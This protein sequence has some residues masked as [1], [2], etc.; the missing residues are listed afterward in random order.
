MPHVSGAGPESPN[1][2]LVLESESQPGSCLLRDS[3]DS[4]CFAPESRD[5]FQ[6]AVDL[7]NEEVMMV[8]E[9]EACTREAA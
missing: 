9:L 3:E 8:S 2:S 1:S 5:D 7:P 4:V 6:N